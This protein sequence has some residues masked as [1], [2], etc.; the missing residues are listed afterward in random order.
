MNIDKNPTKMDLFLFKTM[1]EILFSKN[2]F[3]SFFYRK[4][5]DEIKIDIFCFLLIFFE[6]DIIILSM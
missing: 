6:F 2:V 1:F 3:F 5:M 4:G